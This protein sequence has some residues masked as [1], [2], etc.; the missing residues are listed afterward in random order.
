VQALTVPDGSVTT[1]KIA[2]GAVT[3]EKLAQGISQ[4]ST[5]TLTLPGWVSTTSKTSA[6]FGAITLPAK[7]DL[8]IMGMWILENDSSAGGLSAALAVDGVKQSVNVISLSTPGIGFTV[9]RNHFIP[10]VA[11]GTHTFSVEID[12]F[13]FKSGETVAIGS[14]SVM[15]IRAVPVK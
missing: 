11:A 7:S 14:D 2:D 6:S 15:W 8:Y 4:E 3:S 5:F 12:Q 1:A 13:P 9:A 10:G